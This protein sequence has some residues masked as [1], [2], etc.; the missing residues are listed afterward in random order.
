MDREKRRTGSSINKTP[1]LRGKKHKKES[2]SRNPK[3]AAERR[4][5]GREVKKAQTDRCMKERAE[6]V[7]RK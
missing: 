7:R 4:R 6:K 2:R 3:L 5:D 1:A